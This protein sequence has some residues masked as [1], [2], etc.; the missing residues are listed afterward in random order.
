VKKRP[1]EYIAG[2]Q[3]Y[4]S[5]EGDEASMRYTIERVGDRVLL[6]ASDFPH[7]IDL[8][9]AKHEVEE[10][11]EREDLSEQTKRN[12]LHDNIERFYQR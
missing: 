7:E 10:L 4:F 1:S 12:I 3:I 6:F 5:C 9:R 11:L 2:G 8:A